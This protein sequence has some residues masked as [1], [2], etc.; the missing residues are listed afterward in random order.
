MG[1]TLRKK[2]R[3]RGNA[4]GKGRKRKEKGNGTEKGKIRAKGKG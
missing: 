4:T 1:K 2:M 3:K